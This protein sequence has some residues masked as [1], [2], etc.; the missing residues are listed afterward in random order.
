MKLTVKKDI[1]TLKA[2]DTYCIFVTDE[3]SRSWTD[4]IHPSINEALSSIDTEAVTGK[5]G[6]HFFVPLKKTPSLLVFGLG[7]NID[8]TSESIRKLG[9]DLAA[10]CISKNITSISFVPPAPGN[11]IEAEC[12]RFIAEGIVLSNYKFE[13]FKTKDK[14]KLIENLCVYSSDPLAPSIINEIQIIYN[15]TV[16]CRDLIND[17]S[18]NSTPEG[19]AAAAKSLASNKNIKCQILGKKQIEELKLGLL[20][21]VNQG[22]ARPP[23]LVVLSYKGAPSDKSSIALVGKGLTFDSGGMNLKTSGHIEDMRMD[24]AGA[25]TVMYAFKSAVELNIKK[26][27]YAVMP[28]TENMISNTA[29]RPGDVFTAYNGLTVEIGNTDAEGRLILADA[30]AYTVDK[31]KPSCIIDMA[32]LT[33]ACVVTFGETVAGLISTD[34]E[35]TEK[36]RKSAD[37]T[38]ERLWPLP[39][40]SDYE[41]NMK[42]KIA[43]LCNTASEKNSGTI[44]GAAFLK[45]FVGNIPWAH[46]DIAGTAWNTK[47][48]GYRPENATAFGI[49]LIVDFLSAL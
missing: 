39:L 18:Y 23:Q 49:R 3:Q 13:K 30:L 43:D 7:K 40:Y 46:I 41:E 37:R 16:L 24:M 5:Y 2:E 11:F 21:A 20:L 17:A 4:R 1:S 25:A 35:L 8:L 28:L 31:I 29:Y 47:A 27:I 14:K 22:S 36:L 42:S 33:G 44:H 9:A 32:T 38:G 34:E 15:N 12:T 45:N 48:R 10:F 19:I 6:E 26:N